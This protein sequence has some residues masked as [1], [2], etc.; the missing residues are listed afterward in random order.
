MKFL[1][2][3]QFYSRL[4]AL[5]K[6]VSLT[7]E[8]Q[9]LCFTGL[10][11][12]E[13]IQSLIPLGQA[14]IT[15]S[16]FDLL[17][18][19]FLSSQLTGL[20]GRLLMLLSGQVALAVV[21]NGL[22]SARGYFNAELGRQLNLKMQLLVFRKINALQGLAPFEDPKI[23]NKIQLA[24]QG[25]QMGPQQIL[26]ILTG[27]LRS[28][29][30]LISFLG[31]L[32]SFSPLLTGLVVLAA[33]PQLYIQLK[34]GYQHYGIAIQN[35]PKQRLA[36]YYSYLLSAVYYAKEIRLFNLGEYF[37][38]AFT[39]LTQDLNNIARK[40]QVRE[41]SLQTGLSLLSTLVSNGT[42]I[43]VVWQAFEKR[44]S[45]GDVTFFTS[46]VGSIQS[47]FSTIIFN[48]AGFNE[49]F[50]FY[51]S[52]A[53]LIA[54]EQPIH[55]SPHPYP[56]KQ[57]SSGIELRN[58]S[59]R[60]NPELPWVV[61]NVD[62]KIDAGSCLALV[63]LNGAGKSTLVKLLTRMYDPTEGQILWDG[64]DL[65]EFD[66]LAL[67]QRMG[68]IFQ[69]FIR[70]DLSILENIALGD[71]TRLE[72]EKLDA[73]EELARQAAMKVGIHAKVRNLPKGYQTVASRWLAEDGDG[74]DL[75]GGEWQKIALAR[76]LVRDAEFLILDEP[77]A[78]LDPQAE[79]EIY[80]SFVNLVSKR[81]SLLISHRFSTVR[82]ADQV[83]VL[84][85]GKIAEC[86]KHEE[87]IKAKGNYF[88]LYEMQAARY[89]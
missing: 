26:S 57:L 7:W 15:K 23:Q 60:Y 77:T 36:S 82:M 48:M 76:M 61:R 52:Y 88:R 78:A 22:G 79:Y 31:V 43:A 2:D 59:F 11:V 35:T 58:V 62:L 73:A 69:D 75:S 44:I 56:I 33:L 65:R 42:F 74:I 16:I 46:A 13:A 51:S 1:K 67:R 64:V 80:N 21:S 19:G 8:A 25:A 38:K 81:T 84:E 83:A 68:V 30:T 72:S 34:I 87:L 40:Q 17:A 6:M 47:A 66:L 85:N 37:I 14:W 41:I 10:L 89:R 27:F 63:G 39:R 24:S 9:R 50:L 20:P 29:I 3:K 18:N 54:I 70:Y 4:K 45:L 86:G 49:S 53:E 12:L 32:I 5:G 71:V 55:L 28:V